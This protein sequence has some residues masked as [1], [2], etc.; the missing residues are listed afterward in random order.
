MSG[1]GDPTVLVADDEEGIRVLCRVNLELAGYEVV[2]AADGLRALEAARDVH[3]D[4]IFLDVMMP[5][6]DGWEV[7]RMLKEDPATATIPVVMLTART[8]EADQIRAWGEGVMQYLAKPFSPEL[9]EEYAALAMSPRDPDADDAQRERVIEQ[10]RI[11]EE[12]RRRT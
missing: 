1:P 5:S 2:E 11:L 6:M 7:L 9:L 3:P 4:V 12:L 10:L 8:S